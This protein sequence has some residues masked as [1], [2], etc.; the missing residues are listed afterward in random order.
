MAATYLIKLLSIAVAIPGGWIATLLIRREVVPLRVRMA[1]VLAAS[2]LLGLWAALVMPNLLLLAITLGLAWALLVLGS[3]DLLAFR[4]P[5]LLTL[6]LT[7]V[8][9]LIAVKLPDNDP[10][11]HFA[12]AALGFAALYGIAV[13]Y[14]GI[15]GREGLGLG[16]AKLAAAAGA[17]L[18]WRPLPAV[19]LIACAAAFIAIG[20]GFARR[21]RNVLV[22]EIA[23]G[24][25][26][27][28]AFWIVWIS[29]TSGLYA[30][31]A[32]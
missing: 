12:G 28:L 2:M 1:P 22:E 10:I 3:I 19:L 20:I 26:L 7:A 9:L 23:F 13:A 25:P 16:D 18:G 6:P 5:D 30:E 17:W 31:I 8:G 32:F 11:A 15:R 14:R 4:L 27:C 24:A 21:G 29:S